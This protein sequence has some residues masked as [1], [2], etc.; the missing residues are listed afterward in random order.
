MLHTASANC[1]LGKMQHKVAFHQGLHYLLSNEHSLGT[2]IHHF[3]EILTGK[4]YK[5]NNSILIVIICM[6]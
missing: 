1:L 3:L 5:M 2:E 4:K 6:G